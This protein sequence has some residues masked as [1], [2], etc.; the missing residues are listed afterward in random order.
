MAKSNYDKILSL[1]DAEELGIQ[2]VLQDDI[3][4]RV[5]KRLEE[6]N[7]ELESQ[8]THYQTIKES[9]KKP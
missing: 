3:T 1:F 5:I 6:K 2:L 8:K 9:I 7:D 4:K